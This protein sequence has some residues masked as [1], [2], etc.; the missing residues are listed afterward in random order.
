M[1]KTGK[2]LVCIL[3]SLALLLCVL[4]TVAADGA[5][6]ELSVF[7]ASDIH[8]RPQSALPPLGEVNELPG[9]PLYAHANTK[10]MLTYEADAILHEFL[11][12]F[13]ASDTEYLLIP[14]DVSE[15]G[16]WDEHLAF[17]QI[18]R[19]F[20]A[21]T[22]KKIFLIPGNHDIR[23]AAS[24]GRLDLSDFLEVYADIGYDKTLARHDH[25]ASYTA[26]L[27]G[28]YRLLAIDACIYREDGSRVS[29]DL[30]AWL[31]AQARQAAR[32]G[33][34]LIGMVHH[35]VL[36]HFGLES[37]GGN[38]LCLDNYKELAG[39]FAD[40]GIK[41]IFTGHEHANDISTAVSAK[42]NRI[43]DIETG[44][45]LSYPNAYREVCFRDTEVEI[46]TNYIDTIDISLLP[47][48]YNEAQRALLANDFPA[49]SLGF[50][51][52]G[53]RGFAYDVPELTKKIT[54]SLRFEEGTKEY[55][56]VDEMMAI[57]GEAL[58]LPL[59]DTAGTDAADSVAELAAEAGI[60][61]DAS[62]Y[63][64]VID[65]A[66]DIFA[67]HY[68]GDENIDFDSVPVRLFLQG[69]GAV[70]V[71]VFVQLP[72]RT[73]NILFA[74]LALPERGF[75]LCDNPYTLPAKM[76]Y[77]KTASKLLLREYI[78]PL[79]GG[80]INDISAPADLNVTLE[81]YGETQPLAGDAV[82][83]TPWATLLRLFKKLLSV[84][85]NILCGLAAG[86][87]SMRNA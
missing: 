54:K 46:K 3:L 1:K 85:R 13:E 52:A 67:G 26:E 2:S 47:D 84:Y 10:S 11:A 25:S 35:S 63:A 20:Q 53:L 15:D 42:G 55:A 36:K 30:Y 86:S 51:R 37:I 5:G 39:Q 58:R 50:F 74:G 70:L 38:M 7:V 57:L 6:T 16:Q 27:D 8:Y 83:V 24:G 21:R 87:T 61:L 19:A 79:L 40:W 9:D 69:L 17:A 48:G 60:T 78:R 22:G 81:P 66:A 41:Y 34:K 12:R 82:P 80:I 23:T 49:Y 33:K 65:I 32:D 44:C 62:D 71:Y 29:D 4:P 31:E 77:M 75:T 56:A 14:G 68:A 72:V 43:F 64:D 45:L 76:M 59:Y 28:D 73:A 18:L